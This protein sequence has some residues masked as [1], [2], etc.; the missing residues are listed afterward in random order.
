MKYGVTMN[1]A[2]VLIINTVTVGNIRQPKAVFLLAL[3]HSLFRTQII[4]LIEVI[5]T[6]IPMHTDIQGMDVD[7]VLDIA[8]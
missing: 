8:V 4:L 6:R 5:K 1:L 2:G 3:T 7:K